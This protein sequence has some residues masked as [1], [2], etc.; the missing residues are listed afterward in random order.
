MKTYQRELMKIDV[1]LILVIYVVVFDCNFT[2]KKKINK[3]FRKY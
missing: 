3:I 2:I 1:C